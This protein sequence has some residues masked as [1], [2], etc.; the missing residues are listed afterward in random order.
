V[1]AINRRNGVDVGQFYYRDLPRV[2]FD[3]LVAELG[4]VRA[5]A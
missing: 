3:E 1:V 5:E 2:S 4:L